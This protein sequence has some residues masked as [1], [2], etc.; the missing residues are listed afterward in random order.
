MAPGF[1]GVAIDEDG[2][3]ASGLAGS[4]ATAAALTPSSGVREAAAA[5]GTMLEGLDPS[6]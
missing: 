6:D 4:I 5:E 2:A 1:F 3:A